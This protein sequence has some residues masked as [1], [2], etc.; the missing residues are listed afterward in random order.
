MTGKIPDATVDP[1]GELDLPPPPP[2]RI[3]GLLV[4]LGAAALGLVVALAIRFFVG[5]G[6]PWLALLSALMLGTGPVAAGWLLWRRG[7]RRRWREVAFQCADELTQSIARVVSISAMALFAAGIA[8]LSVEPDHGEIEATMMVLQGG[9][10][11][12][13]GIMFDLLWRGRPCRLRRMFGIGVDTLCVTLLLCVGGPPTQVWMFAYIWIGL[14]SALSDGRTGAIVSS[15]AGA[16]GLAVVAAATGVLSEAP[17]LIVGVAAGLMLLPAQAG[18]LIGSVSG[19]NGGVPRR[20]FRVLLAE[21]SGYGGR[22]LRRQ[23]ER[24]GHEV[25]IVGDGD[26]ALD[27]LHKGGVDVIL[28]D[29]H[30]RQPSA[31]DIVRMYRFMRSEDAHLPIVGLAPG[32][33][34]AIRKRSISAGMNEVL[35]MPMEGFRLLEAVDR[36]G[37]ASCSARQALETG[38]IASISSHPRF[39]AVAEPSI[40]EDALDALQSL[41]PDNGFL[42]D[43]ISV[44]LVDGAELIDAMCKALNEGDV[45]N[46]REHADSLGSSSTHIGAIRLV[47]LLARCR[48]MPTR[49]FKEEG[50]Q[51]MLQIQDEFR[52]VRTALQ[53][54]VWA[55]RHSG[56]N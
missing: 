48:D 11:V 37:A 15:A 36:L 2:V 32:L 55:L 39:S 50:N 40:D 54:H 30:L 44:F 6:S 45:L 13:W 16:L 26:S 53:S 12:A 21:N 8:V 28:I 41:D 49:G 33:T 3:T 18:W 10:L 24:A 46:F 43:V 35:P 22:S 42:E 9:S 23:L 25:L 51:R 29:L 47:K 5:D 4:S 31:L 19:R 27:L 17:F 20:N 7:M 56:F 1:D 52:R 14:G 38:V 34:D